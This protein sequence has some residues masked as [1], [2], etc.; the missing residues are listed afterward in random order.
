MAVS[1]ENFL[2]LAPQAPERPAV[3]SIMRT[4]RGR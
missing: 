1:F 4:I 3:Q 2:K